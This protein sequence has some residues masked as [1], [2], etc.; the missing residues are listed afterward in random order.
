[1]T[2]F[3][4][5][6]LIFLVSFMT[7]VTQ[8]GTFDTDVN[9][10]AYADAE[11]LQK[12]A[13][14]YKPAKW[15][16]PL[17]QNV[18]ENMLVLDGELAVLSL[19]N[20]RRGLKRDRITLIDLAKGEML[21]S[22]SVT[23]DEKDISIIA[24]SKKYILIRTDSENTTNLITLKLRSGQPVWQ[25]EI[26]ATGRVMVQQ[27]DSNHVVLATANNSKVEYQY[28]NISTGDK[29]WLYRTTKT[30]AAITKLI[31]HKKGIVVPANQ[32]AYLDAK[33][34][35]VLWKVKIKYNNNTAP[36]VLWNND[37]YIVD[38]NNKLNRV[39][40]AKGKYIW[41]HKNPNRYL[42]MAV[43][44]GKKQVFLRGLENGTVGQESVVIMLDKKRGR[45]K[46]RQTVNDKLPLISNLVD[47]KNHVYVGSPTTLYALEKSTGDIKF[48][49]L[50]S[51]SQLS[52]YPLMLRRFDKKIVFIGELT[53]A[54]YHATTGK[55]YYRRGL[56][57]INPAADL[58][59][60]EIS[61]KRLT[62]KRKEQ[63]NKPM[64]SRVC[65]FCQMSAASQTRADAIYR[66]PERFTAGERSSWRI[67]VSFSRMYAAMG[68]YESA[69]NFS[70]KVYEGLISQMDKENLARHKLIRTTILGAY[71]AMITEKYVYRP[72]RSLDL[73]DPDA[74]EF[75]Q[76]TAINLETGKKSKTS[77]SVPYKDYGLWVYVDEKRKIA[78]QQS[79]GF[80][81]NA[82]K[83]LMSYLIAKPVV[84]PR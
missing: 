41:S 45:L 13:A 69:L 82:D 54:A 42:I 70:Q 38:V 81:H 50:V 19:R 24:I 33:T 78:Y 1:M 5:N 66:N 73:I 61:I 10:S 77:M 84:L 31:S 28:I 22:R 40:L 17:N 25:K 2:R 9:V 60:L 18:I 58:S 20:Y 62:K 76:I 27:M 71:P 56:T 47:Y 65:S 79:I 12:E 57:G 51:K 6:T 16:I 43:D 23:E 48:S 4:Q 83:P 67:N 15:K 32:L 49:K 35:R 26:P 75:M 3:I 8:A 11:Q 64:E 63:R 21:W 74:G 68:V 34:G 30:G 59:A 80:S 53:V 52:L 36:P 44:V 14:K 46:W 39:N 72:T 55:K 37:L 7:P 29:L